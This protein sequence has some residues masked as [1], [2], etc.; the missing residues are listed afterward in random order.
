M[1]TLNI[2]RRSLSLW[3]GF[4]ELF[5]NLG[6]H[7]RRKNQWHYR[8]PWKISRIEVLKSK[9]IDVCFGFKTPF[10]YQRQGVILNCYLD[11]GGS[12]FTHFR[13]SNFQLLTHLPGG[14]WTACWEFRFII[15][16]KFRGIHRRSDSEPYLIKIDHLDH[17]LSSG[18]TIFCP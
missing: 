18:T 15:K 2:T 14:C 16:P 10:P 8:V 12:L 3:L 4:E 11:Y 9:I 6:V 5:L 7:I 1:W 17:I 13:C